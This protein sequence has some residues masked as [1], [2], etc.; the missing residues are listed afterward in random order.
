MTDDITGRDVQ[1]GGKRLVV[2][3]SLF[4]RGTGQSLWENGIFQN[5]MLLVLLRQSPLVAEAV[6]VNGGT[7]E[8]DP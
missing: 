2:R 1:N 6:M 3:V 8:T 7:S 5:C 4:V